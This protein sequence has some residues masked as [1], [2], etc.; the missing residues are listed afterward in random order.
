MVGRLLAGGGLQAKGGENGPV[1][2]WSLPTRHCSSQRLTYDMLEVVG[3]GKSGVTRFI[4]HDRSCTWG[5]RDRGTFL[6]VNSLPSPGE[7]AILELGHRL[8]C[9]L[10]HHQSVPSPSCT[11]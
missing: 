1:R 9:R 6:N 10:D 11:G 2:S 5:R 4:L 8:G 7:A 3:K